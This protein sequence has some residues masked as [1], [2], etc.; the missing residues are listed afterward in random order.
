MFTL[1]MQHGVGA[2]PCLSRVAQSAI[3]WSERELRHF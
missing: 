1:Q 3:A 2:T